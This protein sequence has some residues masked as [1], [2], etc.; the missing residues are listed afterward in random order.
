MEQLTRS[1]QLGDGLAREMISAL[2][3]VLLRLV[4][5][6]ADHEGWYANIA[7]ETDAGYADELARLGVAVLLINHPYFAKRQQAFRD[8]YRL[9]GHQLDA[10][11]QLEC[12]RLYYA[13]ITTGG[14]RGY[15][16]ACFTAPP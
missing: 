4:I 16:C 15:H 7:K 6:F 3:R 9:H 2:P 5:D 10:P 11:F 13:L 12:E 14:T 8:L 1:A